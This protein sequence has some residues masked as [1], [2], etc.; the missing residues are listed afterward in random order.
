M[1]TT[2]QDA[3]FHRVP[4][5]VEIEWRIKRLSQI[6]ADDELAAEIAASDIDLHDVERM[7]DAGCKLELAWR[8]M[9]PFEWEVPK[10]ELTKA[11]AERATWDPQPQVTS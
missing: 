9:R 7:L 4:N 5:D 11:E 3:A 10:R 6:G 1:T 2:T 8:I